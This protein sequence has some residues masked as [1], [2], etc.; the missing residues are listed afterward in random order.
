MCGSTSDPDPAVPPS[1][2]KLPLRESSKQRKI[3]LSTIRRGTPD[4]RDLQDVESFARSSPAAN[5]R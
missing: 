5:T 4:L 1:L 2:I 3:D